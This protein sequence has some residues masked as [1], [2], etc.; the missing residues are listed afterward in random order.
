MI[1]SVELDALQLNIDIPNEQEPELN[2]TAVMNDIKKGLSPQ[3]SAI[4]YGRKISRPS[5]VWMEEKRWK[6]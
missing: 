5:L 6:S 3:N 4:Q 1:N 2:D